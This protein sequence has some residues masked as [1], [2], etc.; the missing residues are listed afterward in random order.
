VGLK[1]LWSKGFFNTPVMVGY[2]K[3]SFGLKGFL[4][5]IFLEDLQV[6]LENMLI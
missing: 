5:L 3:D 1:E 6:C 4:T 2:H